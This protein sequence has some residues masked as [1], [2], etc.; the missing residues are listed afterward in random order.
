MSANLRPLL[1]A[2]LTAA[3]KDRDAVAVRA[4]RTTIAAIDNAEA[5]EVDQVGATT[6]EQSPRATWSTE[7]QRETLTGEAVRELVSTEIGERLSAARSFA[8]I[9]QVEYVKQL[10]AEAAVLESVLAEAS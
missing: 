7:V 6:I 1:R 8:R 4:L 9:G 2:R 3:M 10:R 5:P